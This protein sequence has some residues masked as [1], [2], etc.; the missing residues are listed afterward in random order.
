MKF[1]RFIMRNAALAN[2]PKHI[3]HFSKF[4]PSPLSMKQFLDFGSVNACEK[5]SFKFLRQELPVRLANIMKEIR[6]LP[7]RLLSTPSAQL[8]HS[9]YVQSLME[10]LEFLDKSPEDHEVLQDF[11]EA[12]VTIRN[13]HNDVVPT[14]AQ[15]VIEYKETFGQ[16]PVTSQNIQ[17]FLDRFYMSRISI[18]MLIN[19]HTLI[20]D[21]ASQPVPSTIGCID[22]HCRV[23]EVIQDAYECA[24]LLCEQFYMCSPDL[25]LREINA[26]LSPSTSPT[27]PRTSTTCSSSSLRTQ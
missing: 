11:V 3:D 12:L 10:L 9:W 8:V 1:A 5:T 7:P 14:M 6:L 2:V 18:R 20:F 16:D 13:R 22:P 25:K 17:Y 27:S 24:K 19:Q 26:N 23:T 21:S 15:G 4:S